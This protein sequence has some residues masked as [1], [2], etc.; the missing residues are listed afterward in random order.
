MEA[1]DLAETLTMKACQDFELP[2]IQLIN[3]GAREKAEPSALFCQFRFQARNHAL[4]LFYSVFQ[5]VDVGL[6]ASKGFVFIIH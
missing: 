3:M 2:R 1:V 5:G 6:A 4:L